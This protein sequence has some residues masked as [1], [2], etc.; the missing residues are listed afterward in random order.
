MIIFFTDLHCQENEPHR[1]ACLS[2]LDNLYK[3]HK[4][5]TII[6]GGDLF[7]QS[8]HHH[9]L[10]YDVLEKI[11]KFKDFRIVVGNHE[12]SRKLG[13]ILL[14]LKHHSNITIY[15][16]QKEDVIEGI[17]FIFLPSKPHKEKIYEQINGIWDYSISHFEPIQESFINEGIELK[18]KTNV[19]HLFGHIHKHNEYKDNHN[20]NILIAGSCI[21]TR[22]G[23]QDWKKYYYILHKDKYEKIL[24][25][26]TFTYEDIEY[27]NFP[28]NKNNILNIKNAPSFDSVYDLYKDYYIRKEG[29]E[30]NRVQNN[31]ITIVE[32]TNLKDTFNKWSNENK[33]PLEIVNCF[34]K[35]YCI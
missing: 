14:P 3:N 34:N 10:V 23:E 15:D 6:C 28:I 17:S 1:E 16:E 32:T 11:K 20:N 22:Y 29:I 2:F 5:D 21:S 33:I 7:H 25:K 27:G 8:S 12:I 35:Y 31:S 4:D 24:I 19:C 26:E 13:N 9:N 30:I 18:F